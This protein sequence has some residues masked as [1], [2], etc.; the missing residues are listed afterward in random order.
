[1]SRAARFLVIAAAWALPVAWLVVGLLLRP[2]DGTVV[3]SPPLSGGPGWGGSLP[4][5]ETYGTTPLEVDDRITEVDGRPVRDWLSGAASD[6]RAV[7]DDVT[8]TVVQVGASGLG[9]EFQRTVTLHRFPVA[10]ALR[11]DLPVVVTGL[12]L[13]LAGGVA[14]FVRPELGAAR[15]SVGAMTLIPAGLAST[16]WGVGAIDL[17]GG[18]GLWP[19][20]T[21][22]VL[23]ALG[24]GLA[25]LS[26]VTLR[27]PPGR[28]EARP[29]ILPVALLLPF[30]GYAAWAVGRFLTVDGPEQT[31]SLLSVAVPAAVLAV[32]AVL[33]ALASGYRDAPGREARLAVRLALLVLAAGLAARL[34]LG[35]LPELVAGDPV[36]PWDALMLLLAA[37]VVAGLVVAVVGYRLDAIEPAVRRA[38]TQGAV[39]AVVGAAFVAVASTVGL[40]TDAS[41][42]P[43]L[44]GGA[45]ALLVLPL[46]VAVQRGVRRVVY[47]DRDLPR[48]VVSA[49]RRLD[50]TTGTTEALT[51]TLTLLSRRLR[52]S[53]AV[54]EV[55]AGSGEDVVL[56]SVGEP[57]G[58][59][60]VSVEL[61]V[62]GV[63]LGSLHLEV[64]PD[65]D[66]FGRGDRRLLEDVGAEVGTLVQAVLA[67]SELQRSRQEIVTAREEER[68]RLR[69]DLHD[70]LGP[71]LAVLAMRLE[72]AHELVESDPEQAAEVVAGLADLARDE[73]AEV[74]RLVDGLRPAALDQLGLVSALRQRAAQHELT[75]GDGA[76]VWTVDADD[77]VEPLPAAVEVAAYRIVVEAVTNAV[78]HSGARA[79]TVTLRRDG[80]DLHVRV[81]DDG[82][83]LVAG[84]P[85]G[86]GLFSMRERAQEVGGVCTVT[87]HAR[88]TTVE[89]RLP[90]RLDGGLDGG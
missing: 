86:V 26:A 69:R 13:M 35:D 74:R 83:G 85:A 67:N 76:V 65:R 32:P 75:A 45:V 2:S 39:A 51:E 81:R 58:R 6:R 33:L 70:G 72:S 84:S 73:I 46:A 53:H 3:W 38:V 80:T 9:Q 62:G 24:L 59:Q 78:K 55:P 44:A 31:R 64:A 4:V 34:L 22:E 48:T 16:R 8:Y 43:I 68:R 27:A 47:G 42:G 10:A 25:V 11:E 23:C 60:P 57:Q 7:G 89:A 20:V 19:H 36:I 66:P 37:P 1:M 56:A 12:L 14:F 52:L 28:L 77:S 21:S 29:W 41:V 15:S 61:V 88:G 17:A 71:S 54:I 63:R 87:S 50:A 49:L 40:A 90:L 82:H 5:T 79:C 18:R 30:A